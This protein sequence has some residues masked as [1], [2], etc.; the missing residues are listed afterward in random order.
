MSPQDES[1]PGVSKESRSESSLRRWG[2]SSSR[3]WSASSSRRGMFAGRW[4]LWEGTLNSGRG[5]LESTAARYQGCGAV[6]Y[7]L[8]A[9]AEIGR[10]MAAV[11]GCSE[12]DSREDGETGEAE[13]E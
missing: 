10:L 4:E 13:S 3:A 6:G 12:R 1:E 9:A 5:L 7:L 8:Q 11:T 2:L